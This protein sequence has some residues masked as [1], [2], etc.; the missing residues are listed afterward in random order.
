VIFGIVLKRM[1]FA[2]LGR[3]AVP[4]GAHTVGVDPQTHRAWTV[5]SEP[6]GD[7]VQAF[8]YTP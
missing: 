4:R 7:F 2:E 8:S 3:T 1:V 5:W 6:A